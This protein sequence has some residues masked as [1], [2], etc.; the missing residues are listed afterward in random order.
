[1]SQVPP[2]PPARDGGAPSLVGPW[3]LGSTIAFAL[4]LPSL[5]FASG[6]CCGGPAWPGVALGLVL[7]AQR[8]PI[9]EW[10]G[11]KLG[12]LIAGTASVVRAILASLGVG[13]LGAGDELRED[14]AR[15]FQQSLADSPDLSP[16]EIEALEKQTMAIVD[17]V[18]DHSAELT[19]LTYCIGGALFGGLFG[20]ILDKR[21][22]RRESSEL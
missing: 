18:I 20:L 13:A 15:Q 12:F 22:R 2:E 9:R 10:D 11:L 16:S 4:S 3:A 7:A 1:M 8:A 19:V 17:F 14:F 6:L 21:R 5:C